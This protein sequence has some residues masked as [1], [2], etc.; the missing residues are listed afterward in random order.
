MTS[1]PEEIFWVVLQA[2]RSIHGVHTSTKALPVD[3]GIVSL[4]T[5]LETIKGESLIIKLEGDTKAD[6][7][8][9][10][11]DLLSRWVMEVYPMLLPQKVNVSLEGLHVLCLK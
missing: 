10:Q 7:T 11:S 4:V 3:R 1:T 9:V 2:S 8:G 5:S 6:D